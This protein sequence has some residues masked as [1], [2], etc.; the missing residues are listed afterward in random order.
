MSS[1]AP[2]NLWIIVSHDWQ[3]G[4]CHKV[5]TTLKGLREAA[6]K[7]NDP[8]FDGPLEVWVVTLDGSGACEKSSLEVLGVR[9]G[10]V[11]QRSLD[12]RMRGRQLAI[13]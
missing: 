8:I 10:K 2:L 4:P 7:H 12:A 13:R 1:E 6:K 11:P 9:V 5:Y 3:P